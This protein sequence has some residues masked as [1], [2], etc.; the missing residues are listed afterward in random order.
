MAKENSSSPRQVQGTLVLET[1]EKDLNLTE[2]I[3]VA[4]QDADRC[5]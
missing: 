5:K 2:L 3:L 1:R 4:D